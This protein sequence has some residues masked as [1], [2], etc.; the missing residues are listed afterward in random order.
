MNERAI[1]V[2][3][4]RQ[5]RYFYPIAAHHRF[6]FLA[7]P[8][9]DLLFGSQSFFTGRTFL[10]KHQFNRQLSGGITIAQ[11]VMVFANTIFEIVSMSGAIRTISKTQNVNPEAHNFCAP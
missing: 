1:P 8:T 10:A 11:T 4:L 7:A 6:L 5:T 9:F 2:R 3:T